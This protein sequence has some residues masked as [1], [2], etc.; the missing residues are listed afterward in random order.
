[1]ILT[2][3][4]K[5]LI[6]SLI[7]LPISIFIILNGGIIFLLGI[8]FCLIVSIFEWSKLTINYF[9]KIIGYF[10]ILFSFY[11]FFHMRNNT[12]YGNLYDFLVIFLICVSSD[13]GG[14]IFGNLFKGPK[15]TRIS[16]NKTY[17]GAIGSFIFSLIVALLF[18][19]NIPNSHLTFNLNFLT[20]VL[21]ISFICQIGDLT[22]SYYKRKSKVKD[23]GNLIPGH[24]GIL[25]RIDGMIFVFPVIFLLNNIF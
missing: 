20:Y 22:I 21:F 9:H 6:S 19:K 10:F 23:T 15:L 12:E 24:G 7:L 25:D 5:R 16:P 8:L 2:N 1:M 4:F 17:S 3:N 11:T 18:L 14:Y 13:L